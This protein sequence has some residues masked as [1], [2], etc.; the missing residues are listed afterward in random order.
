M[1]QPLT[2]FFVA[3]DGTQRVFP[4]L[5][6]EYSNVIALGSFGPDLFYVKDLISNRILN[7]SMSNEWEALS[8]AFH[9]CNSF[10]LFTWLLNNIKS[11]HNDNY[12]EQRLLKAFAYGY[13]SH[14][15]TDC[16]IHPFVYRTTQD[17][18]T[19]HSPE[20]NYKAHK[21]LETQ[22]DNI[23]L[24]RKTDYKLSRFDP[25]FGLQD[26]DDNDKLHMTLAILLNEGIKA[27]YSQDIDWDYYFGRYNINSDNHPIHDAYKD[28][29]AEINFTKQGIKLIRKNINGF[30][31][32]NI[33][34]T[35]SDS[36]H[37]FNSERKRWFASSSNDQLNFSV[38][39][40]Y[41]MAVTTTSDVITASERFFS[42]C[43]EN[44]M[45]FFLN[46]ETITAYLKNDFNLDTG[47]PSS[48]NQNQSL[49]SQDANTRYAFGVEQLH[50]LYSMG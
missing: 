29:E 13:Y 34:I 40:L 44:S 49:L 25:V 28:Y 5:W 39:D 41:E 21:E 20:S 1:P 27:S 32:G 2:H 26:K 15:V 30:I 24:L 37:I 16:L 45:D 50:Q 3:S 35:E 47:L 4:D 48:N 22:I 38:D 14:V 23:L 12:S 19:L 36:P 11:R 31:T 43:S 6:N 9:R 8:D 33:Q 17:H 46:E 7:M 18:W 10:T 42:S